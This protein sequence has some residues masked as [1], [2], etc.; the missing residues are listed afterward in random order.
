MS[1]LISLNINIG[2]SFPSHQ[3][4]LTH[5]HVFFIPNDNSKPKAIQKQTNSFKVVG[6]LQLTSL[7]F[8]ENSEQLKLVNYFRIMVP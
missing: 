5:Q 3:I 2:E 6:K 4:D 7:H 8:S 1:K